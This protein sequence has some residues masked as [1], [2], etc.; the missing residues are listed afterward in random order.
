MT[1]A[2]IEMPLSPVIDTA[3]MLDR[4]DGD[5]ELAC[6]VIGLFLEDCPRRLTAVREALAHGDGKA[7][8]FAAHSFKGSVSTF[9]AA[10]ATAASVRLESIGAAGDLSHA[11]EACTALEHEIER[12]EAALCSLVRLLSSNS[13]V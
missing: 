5:A 8:E 1:T 9:A 11:E 12:L 2:T 4:L 13:H 10:A 6:E 7:L 3:T